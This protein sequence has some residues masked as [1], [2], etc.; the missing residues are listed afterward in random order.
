[1]FGIQRHDYWLTNG[2]KIRR[3][4]VPRYSA[5]GPM[6]DVGTPEFVAWVAQHDRLKFSY[7]GHAGIIKREIVW[8]KLKHG[9]RAYQYWVAYAWPG[10][11]RWRGRRYCKK[12]TVYIGKLERVTPERLKRCFDK[13]IYRYETKRHALHAEREAERRQRRAQSRARAKQRRK[14]REASRSS[15]PRNH[16]PDY[17]K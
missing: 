10:A 5:H 8:R 17:R 9:D 7:K 12:V 13:L 14:E 11:R 16:G 15:S 2:E 3:Y 4:N 1:V 6:I